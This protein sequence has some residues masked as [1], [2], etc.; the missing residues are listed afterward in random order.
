MK[1]LVISSH[2]FY[3]AENFLEKSKGVIGRESLLDEGMFVITS[4]NWVHTFCLSRNLYVYF[5][6]K[7][8]SSVI[9]EQCLNPNSLSAWV[10]RASHVVESRSSL[11]H[12]IFSKSASQLSLA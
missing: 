4:C 6:S 12:S 9:Q 3:I 7:D 2:T 5:L 1:K 10:I 11:Q 8:F